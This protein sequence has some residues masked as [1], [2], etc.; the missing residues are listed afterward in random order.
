[1]AQDDSVRD[2]LNA[3]T[4]IIPC[5]GAA[6]AIGFIGNSLVRKNVA[7]AG[8]IVIWFV[9]AFVISEQDFLLDY[10]TEWNGL[11]DLLGFCI[12]GSLPFVPLSC[13]LYAYKKNDYFHGYVLS[14][15]AWGLIM[16]Q[17][18]RLG[19]MCYFYLWATDYM[20]NYVG[21]QT[22][23]LDIFMGV[24]ALPLG[25]MVKNSSLKSHKK[26]LLVWNFLGLYDLIFGIIMVTLNYIG[27]YSSGE[28][29]LSMFAFFPISLIVFFQVPIAIGIHGL[30][31]ASFDTLAK[32]QD[33]DNPE[34]KVDT[35]SGSA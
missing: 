10:P 3:F 8:A 34:E 28:N 5:I 30:F 13:L 1:M 23:V 20:G 35:I 19:G 24:T 25:L 31:L 17:V 14:T 16:S 7:L 11:D 15:P 18:Y 27:W 26:L 9:G 21:F 4:P 32:A 12:F 29:A 2:A 6:V 22:G 33:S